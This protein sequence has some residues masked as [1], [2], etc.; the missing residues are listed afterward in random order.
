MLSAC[1]NKQPPKP[2]VNFTVKLTRSGVDYRQILGCIGSTKSDT[3]DTN[4][5]RQRRLTWYTSIVTCVNSSRSY[6]LSYSEI[7]YSGRRRISYKEEMTC[8]EPKEHRV[9]FYTNIKYN[10]AGEVIG[11]TTN[12]D[13][14]TYKE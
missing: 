14:Q 4:Y 3:I 5:D 7:K 11:Y 10:E 1:H 2:V 13:G 6:K 9:V 12:L 8:A